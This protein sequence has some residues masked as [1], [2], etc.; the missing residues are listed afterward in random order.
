MVKFNI[1]AEYT[2]E[3]LSKITSSCAK[4]LAKSTGKTISPETIQ[5]AAETA[6]NVMKKTA[7]NAAPVTALDLVGLFLWPL[8]IM[9]YIKGNP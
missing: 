9:M 2:R 8:L 1:I 4:E 6:K 3:S 7:E 5:H